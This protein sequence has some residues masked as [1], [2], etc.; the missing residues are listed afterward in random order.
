M[1]ICEPKS[2][3]S[4]TSSREFNFQKVGMNASGAAPWRKVAAI[5]FLIAV[6]GPFLFGAFY[7]A[8][9]GSNAQRAIADGMAYTYP[10]LD[11]L[12][13]IAVIVGIVDLIRRYR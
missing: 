9:T 12:I 5:A 13:P 3:I 8:Y 2:A 10:Y 7:S 4:G 6:V 1:K 11:Y